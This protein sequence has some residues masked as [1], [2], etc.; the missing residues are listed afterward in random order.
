[1]Y[2]ALVKVLVYLLYKIVSLW[3]LVD[4]TDLEFRDLPSSASQVLTLKVW[5]N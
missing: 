1:M 4:Q 2:T 3:S 5:H